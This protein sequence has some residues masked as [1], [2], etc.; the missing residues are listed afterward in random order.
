MIVLIAIF[1]ILVAT[2][3]VVGCASTKSWIVRWFYILFCT[4]MFTLSWHLYSVLRFSSEHHIQIVMRGGE[5][6]IFFVV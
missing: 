5:C 6:E 4:G 1:N 3:A 2:L